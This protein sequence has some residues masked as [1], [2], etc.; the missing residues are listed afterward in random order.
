MNYL[1]IAGWNWQLPKHELL[2]DGPRTGATPPARSPISGSRGEVSAASG[3][4]T[5]QTA[6]ILSPSSS[7]SSPSPSSSF[8]LRRR[9]TDAIIE[10]KRLYGF[11]SI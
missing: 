10:K 6:A 7:W 1:G 11:T 5:C 2:Q 9:K 8:W 3:R 4:Q